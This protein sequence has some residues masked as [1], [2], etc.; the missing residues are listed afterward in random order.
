MSDRPRWQIH[1]VFLGK[2]SV[3]PNGTTARPFNRP[4]GT[5]AARRFYGGVLQ[6]S[7]GDFLEHWSEAQLSGN[8]IPP[9]AGSGANVIAKAAAT[10]GGFTYVMESELPANTTGV[11]LV[12]TK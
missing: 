10:Q 6:M 4:S 11:R 1:N 3:W 2:T 12:R 7:S 9:T 8:G 5:A